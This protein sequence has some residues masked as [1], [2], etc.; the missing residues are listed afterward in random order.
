MTDSPHVQHPDAAGRT[1]AVAARERGLRRLRVLTAS[2]AAAVVVG[3]GA[4]TVAVASD[5]EAAT[6]G[7]DPADGS[8]QA[9]GIAAGDAPGASTGHHADASSGAS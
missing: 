6:T 9:G 3:T 8:T 1:E 4:L 5:T 2:L 7:T